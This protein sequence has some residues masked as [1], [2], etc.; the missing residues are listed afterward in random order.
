MAKFED[1]DDA[2]DAENTIEDWMEQL[3][4]DAEVTQEGLFLKGSA[5]LDIDDAESLFQGV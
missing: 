5:Q 3:Y 1:E 2:D 4:D